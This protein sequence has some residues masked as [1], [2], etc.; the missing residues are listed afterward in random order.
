VLNSTGLTEEAL[1][2]LIR[3]ESADGSD[4]RSPYARATILARSGRTE[5]AR[6]AAQRALEI[7]PRFE[8]AR[9]MLRNPPGVPQSPRP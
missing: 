2:A 9:E 5:E 3:A 7:N 1:Q 6:R 8:P 4:P